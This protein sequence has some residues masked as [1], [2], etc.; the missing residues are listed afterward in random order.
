[1]HGH[2]DTLKPLL[3][4]SSSLIFQVAPHNVRRISSLREHWHTRTHLH[5]F[6]FV[7]MTIAHHRVC[8]SCHHRLITPYVCKWLQV[9]HAFWT[10]FI[11]RMTHNMAGLQ[12]CLS[13][14]WSKSTILIGQGTFSVSIAPFYGVCTYIVHSFKGGASVA[15]LLQTD[16]S[17]SLSRSLAQRSATPFLHTGI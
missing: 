8:A 9:K 13:R 11:G 5:T 6:D 7:S 17:L 15:V 12:A 2:T 14:D 1:M 10:L 16:C 3:G 4:N